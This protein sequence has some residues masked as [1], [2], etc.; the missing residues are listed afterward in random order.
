MTSAV[1]SK[2]VLSS[3][4]RL[5]DRINRLGA[6]SDDP[7]CLSRFYGTKAHQKAGELLIHWMRE[8]GLT[9]YKDDIGNI[10]GV[11]PSKSSHAKTFVIGSH[12]D[13]VY[14]AG[15]YDGPLGILIGIEIAKTLYRD[16]IELPFNLEII[17]FSDEEGCRFNTAYLG[18]SV[19]AKKFEASWLGRT[20]DDGNTLSDV[21]KINKLNASKLSKHHIAKGQ[22][23]GY[24]EIHIEQGPVLCKANLPVALVSGI[25]AQTRVNIEWKGECGHAGTYPMHMRQDALC[26]FTEFNTEV[27]ML[28]LEYKD[29][30]VATV[31]KVSV[32]PNVSNVIPDSVKHT[33]D[34]RSS[35]DFFLKSIEKKLKR[36]ARIISNRRKVN[37]DWYIMQNNASVVCDEQLRGLLKDSISHCGIQRVL[38]I[39][40]GAGHDAVM[41]SEVAPVSMLFV[42]CKEGKSHTPEEY[43]EPEDI[44]SAL[45]VGYAFIQKLIQLNT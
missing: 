29:N 18:S 7:N 36:H 8:S 30:L 45:G 39:Q 20:D 11:L 21:I 24:F 9:V 23:L 17:A 12:Y 14:N 37:L 15:Y 5:I 2:S 16:R 6:V 42:R 33:L 22:L 27:E 26:A 13:T 31:G 34:L 40:S 41:M 25:A 10:R 38:S 28:G 1:K 35:D 43:V 44:T 4:A 19:I 3:T 32:G